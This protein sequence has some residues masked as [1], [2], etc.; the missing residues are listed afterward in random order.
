MKPNCLFFEMKHLSIPIDV[1][2]KFE[3]FVER[4]FL[5]TQSGF[6][7]SKGLLEANYSSCVDVQQMERRPFEA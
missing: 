1:L 6:G 3:V 4:E 2:K 7:N 5:R